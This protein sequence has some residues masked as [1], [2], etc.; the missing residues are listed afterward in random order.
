MPS[1][2]YGR[3]PKIIPLLEQ[4]G[5][6]EKHVDGGRKGLKGIWGFEVTICGTFD[7]AGHG[8]KQKELG[9]KSKGQR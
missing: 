5:V 1:P 7:E 6:K 9:F 3:E 2:K 8:I 4:K